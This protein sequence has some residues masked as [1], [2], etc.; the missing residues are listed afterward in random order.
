MTLV[1]VPNNRCTSQTATVA[2]T[3]WLPT[4]GPD[5]IRTLLATPISQPPSEV[6]VLGPWSLEY[7]KNRALEYASL[8]FS[9]LTFFQSRPLAAHNSH[10]PYAIASFITRII[11]ALHIGLHLTFQVI[12]LVSN[13]MLIWPCFVLGGF[14][15]RTGKEGERDEASECL[16]W[17][18]VDREAALRLSGD[19]W[20]R[21]PTRNLDFV[22][23]KALCCCRRAWNPY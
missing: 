20:H 6:L 4:L 18:L 15:D 14:G 23:V 21:E 17:F 19:F 12:L 1:D 7:T 8:P 16:I 22:G 2:S 9:I 10:Y 11:A 5:P 3:H 13:W